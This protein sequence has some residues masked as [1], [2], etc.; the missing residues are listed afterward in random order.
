M[1]VTSQDTQFYLEKYFQAINYHSLNSVHI[2]NNHK[3][4]VSLA[5]YR[6]PQCA[7]TLSSLI[8]NAAKP[9]QLVIVICQQNDDKDEDC[10]NSKMDLKGAT[11]K[12]LRLHFTEAK[13]PCWA[14]FLIQQEWQGEEYYLQIDSHMRFVKN[15]DQK[16]KYELTLC[17]EK[18][19][20]SNYVSN[21]NIVNGSLDENPLRGPM[22]KGKEI[23]SGI[24]SY[25]SD[26]IQNLISPTESKGYS[27]CFS[28]SKSNILHDA[29]YDPYTPFLFF[30]EEMD[31]HVRLF[32]HGWGLYVPS[33]PICFTTFN[34]LYRKTFWE[35]HLAYC[36]Q[37]ALLSRTRLN[38]R[39]GRVANCHELL[40]NGLEDYS[41]G[42]IHTFTEF[43][44]NCI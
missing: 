21:Y 14:R 36:D 35:D 31:M 43:I 44:Q 11:I 40:T 6:D 27:A 22:Y 10:L 24:F 2:K 1:T 41:L 20:L 9:E 18:S 26:Y 29:P 30:G 42:S 8:N 19:C 39:F 38:Y 15:W 37:V 12:V 5:T 16:C 34:R 25:E 17:P 33:Q 4:F 32:T 3:I 13:G 28:F 23:F 7:L